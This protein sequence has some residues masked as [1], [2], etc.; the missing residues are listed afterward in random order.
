MFAFNC[1]FSRLQKKKISVFAMAVVVYIDL[2]IILFA[3]Q[4]HSSVRRPVCQ[5]VHTFVSLSS[6]RTSALNALAI[7]F[8]TTFWSVFIFLG[9]RLL[10]FVFSCCCCYFFWKMRWK[11][12]FGI[13]LFGSF[14]KEIVVA[15]LPLNYM[16]TVQRAPLQ[17]PGISLD[18]RWWLRIR[19][20]RF[21]IVHPREVWLFKV[22]S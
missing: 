1:F 4:V 15:F 20:Q 11:V 7:L 19:P 8:R 9:L 12:Q 6:L 17:F 10:R 21:E 18:G 22:N 3:L 2:I 13:F 5:S 16:D 14:R